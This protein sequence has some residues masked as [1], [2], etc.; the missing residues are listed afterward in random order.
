MIVAKL[1]GLEKKRGV[2]LTAIQCLCFILLLCGCGKSDKT[3]KT[4]DAQ[5]KV[6]NVK[7]NIVK[8]STEPIDISHISAPYVVN[9]YL[10][11]GDYV[12]LDKLIHIFDKNTFKYVTS[13]GERGGGPGEIT[14]MGRI[15]SNEKE[16]AFYVIDT[17]RQKILDYSIDSV[18]VDSLYIPKEKAAISK[19]EHPYSFQYVNDTLSFALF[20]KIIDNGNYKPVVSKWNMKTGEIVYMDYAGHP[21][22]KKKRVSFAAS[23]KYG[24]YVEAYWHN[25]LISL[26]STDGYLKYNI[27]GKN[28]N[29]ENSSQNL[30]FWN[31]AFC[32]DKIV[33]SYLG[34]ENI[35]KRKDG[36]KANYPAQLLIFNLEG[37]YLVTL[38][39]GYPIMT[40]C[41]DE[42][43]D[44][45]IFAFDNEMQFGYLDFKQWSSLRN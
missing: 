8:I 2:N 16:R 7:K 31:I 38:N 12:S 6:V 4:F 19:Q 43:N 24:V 41:Y 45:L 25:E 28:W 18:L 1:F 13:I 27:Y 32:K 40:F 3:D 23:A 22:I 39:V 5:K 29:D 14:N 37:D 44:R 17:G 33:A 11:I 10:I 30:F 36:P 42:S 9:D 15:E 20:I 34:G 35:S 26:G 21:K